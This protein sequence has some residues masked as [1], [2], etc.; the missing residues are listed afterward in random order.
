MEE[1]FKFGVWS[2]GFRVKGNV[3][4]SGANF[5]G[6]AER[7]GFDDSY[8]FRFSKIGYKI[9]EVGCF[10]RFGRD[11]FCYLFLDNKCN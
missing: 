3:K 7:P 1:C 10:R 2:I 11:L 5:W 6:R 9:G 4:D 8:N